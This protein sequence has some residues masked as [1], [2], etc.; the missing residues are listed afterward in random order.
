MAKECINAADEMNLEQGLLFERRNFHALFAT[1]DQKEVRKN[2]KF[3][4]G[5]LQLGTMNCINID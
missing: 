3:H 2:E 1:H 4:E 5:L